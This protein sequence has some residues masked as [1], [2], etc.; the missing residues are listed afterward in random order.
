MPKQTVIPSLPGYVWDTRFGSGRYRIILPDGRL[1]ALVSRDEIVSVVR[2]LHDASAARF[3]LL[4]QDAVAGRIAVADFQQAMMLELK[5]LYNASSA[6]AVGGYN[7]MTAVEWG[8]NGQILRGEYA[9]LAGFAQDIADG[10]LTPAQA[11][12]RAR[13][14]AGK[15]YSRFWA[16]HSLQQQAAGYTQERWNT[17]A[18]ERVCTGGERAGCQGLGDLGWVAIGTLPNPGDGSTQCLGACRCDKEFR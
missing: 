5:H 6:L 15:A 18:D 4:A 8:R 7:K 10:K 17:A 12:A 2:N 16:E 3:G 9:Y 13:L 1:G 14:Y 11:D